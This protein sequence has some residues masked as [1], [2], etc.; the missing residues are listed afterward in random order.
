[1]F[2][3]RRGSFRTLDFRPEEQ[4]KLRAAA[5]PDDV[6][7]WHA[8]GT[9]PDAPLEHLGTKSG[10]P[11][12][13]LRDVLAEG[14]RREVRP[15]RGGGLSRH[16]LDVVLVGTLAMV[17]WLAL[18]DPPRPAE[19]RHVRARG[20]I[21]AFQVLNASQL[22]DTT[23]PA[24]EGAVAEVADAAGRVVLRTL[25]AGQPV[26]EAHLGPRLP[27]G[28]LEGRAVMALAAAPTPP[29]AQPR[30]GTTVGLLLTPRAPGG[31][32]AVLADA[33]VLSATRADSAL[34]LLVALPRTD[35]PTAAALLG[36]AEVHVVATPP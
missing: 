26:T 10:I 34:N 36:N 29:D 20:V 21:A 5:L 30:P 16:W 17:A 19:P 11:V 12:A 9:R 4:E 18:R 23:A 28:A 25:A 27:A 13:R 6:A 22:A 15:A 3:G 14:G 24:P 8:A 33:L 2:G 32:G 1:M 31:A 7:V 35:L